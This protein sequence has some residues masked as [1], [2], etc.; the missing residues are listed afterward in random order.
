MWHVSIAPTGIVLPQD[1]LRTYAFEAL[2][3]V[4]A[5]L[6]GQWEEFTGYAFTGYAFHL[7]RRLTEA[8]QTAV[9]DVVD[10]RGTP[11]QE[12]R[13]RAVRRYLPTGYKNFND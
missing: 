1:V 9:G 5:A 10:I 8:E 2:A 11:E 7:R 6:L 3:G 4:G 13:W 12:K